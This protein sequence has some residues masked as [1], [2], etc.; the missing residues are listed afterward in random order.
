MFMNVDVIKDYLSLKNKI[1]SEDYFVGF[2][3]SENQKRLLI[4]EEN[5]KRIFALT[6]K[7]RILETKDEEFNSFF[8]FIE[9]YFTDPQS[10]KIKDIEF[11]KTLNQATA[12]LFSSK[13]SVLNPVIF[14]QEEKP[15]KLSDHT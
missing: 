10:V 3:T 8:D 11:F 1:N 4:K 7:L 12:W 6:Q 13:L 15:L 14:V 2:V 5:S 9:S